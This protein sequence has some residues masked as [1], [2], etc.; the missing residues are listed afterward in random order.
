MGWNHD[1]NDRFGFCFH[2]FMNLLLKRFLMIW[3]WLFSSLL[4]IPNSFSSFS[5]HMTTTTP[6]TTTDDDP[7]HWRRVCFIICPNPEC[8][9]AEVS[10]NNKKKQQQQ[11]Y[12][13]ESDKDICFS[14]VFSHHY[15]WCCHVH[16]TRQHADNPHTHSIFFYSMLFVVFCCYCCLLLFVGSC[17]L[18]LDANL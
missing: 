15:G 6:P 4:S 11:E 13:S 10:N 8:R 12:H 14:D 1:H 7:K 3:C 17:L 2:R 9:Y 16:S 18:D 5:H